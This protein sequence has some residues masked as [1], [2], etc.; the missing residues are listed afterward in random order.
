MEQLYH[1]FLDKI[2]GNLRKQ[3]YEAYCALNLVLDL[4]AAD[5]TKHYENGYGR[6]YAV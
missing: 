4:K 5:M 3:L 2:P 1:I 6:K